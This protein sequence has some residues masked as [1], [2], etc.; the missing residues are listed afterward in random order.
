MIPD[1]EIKGAFEN[2]AR[3]KG[4]KTKKIDSIMLH[5]VLVLYMCA[6]LKK[7]EISGVKIK[8]VIYTQGRI[9]G[10]DPNSQG[11]NDNFVRL[12]GFPA[13]VLHEY[14]VYLRSSGKHK[15]SPNSPLFPN[16]EG[17]SGQKKLSRH[18]EKIPS[19]RIG[20]FTE[21]WD[22]NKLMEYG[23]ADHFQN[24]IK[25]GKTHDEAIQSTARQ[26]RINE[27]TV[28]D[29]L[30]QNKKQ[31]QD[32]FEKLL[33]HW[34][35]LTIKKFSEQEEVDAFRKE[36]IKLINSLQTKDK[37]KIIEMF[38]NSIDDCVARQ[39]P[40]TKNTDYPNDFREVLKILKRAVDESL[41]ESDTRK[42]IER[43]SK[44]MEKY[45]FDEN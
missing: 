9:S 12:T 8:D 45:Y 17:D 4:S 3:L 32:S 38:N 25:S 16:Y 42:R 41:D 6:G 33:I 37:Q 34:D 39:S 36:G 26:Y 13:Q 44:K 5:A 35:E 20:D 29:N 11:G 14:L 28:V 10:I 22:L 15:L 7:K 19:Y 23:I 18:L 43:Y 21:K 24:E 27:R 40:N 30:T 1:N 31:I 2:L